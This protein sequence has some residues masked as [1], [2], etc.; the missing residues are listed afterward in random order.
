MIAGNYFDDDNSS[1]YQLTQ[2]FCENTNDYI[3]PSS[4]EF[5]PDLL[6]DERTVYVKTDFL[7]NQGSGKSLALSHEF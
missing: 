1:I 5:W 2:F 3:N 4:V 6:S 7:V